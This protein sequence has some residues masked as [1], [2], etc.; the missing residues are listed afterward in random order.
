[1][2]VALGFLLGIP[3]GAK[4]AKDANA[5]CCWNLQQQVQALQGEVADANGR[6]SK[7]DAYRAT[8]NQIAALSATEQ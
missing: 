8:L 6:A 3:A 7:S 4:M 1:M 2:L 5:A